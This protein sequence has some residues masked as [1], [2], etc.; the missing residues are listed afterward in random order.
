MKVN[1]KLFVSRF[2]LLLFVH[3]YSVCRLGKYPDSYRMLILQLLTQ[4][5]FAREFTYIYNTMV[6][7]DEFKDM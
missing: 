7:L 3:I 4:L 5:D 2:L 1:F 6:L